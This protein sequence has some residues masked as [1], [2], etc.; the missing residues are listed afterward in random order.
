MFTY[1][2]RS[3]GLKILAVVGVT[4]LATLFSL[5]FLFI[6]AMERNLLEEN[7]TAIGKTADSAVRGLKAIMLSGYTDVATAY[8]GTLKKTEGMVAF[9]I[10]KVDGEEA[11]QPDPDAE[12]DTSDD[13]AP[14]EPEPPPHPFQEAHLKQAIAS[15]KAITYQE[16]GTGGEPMKTTLIPLLN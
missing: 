15:E 14:S 7:A 1:L 11:F 6:T 12:D 8:A 4:G 5:G 2:R 3:I 16:I 10:L 13:A 9:R